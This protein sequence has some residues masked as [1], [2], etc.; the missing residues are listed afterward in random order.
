MAVFVIIGAGHVVGSVERVELHVR[1]GRKSNRPL[2]RLLVSA[3]EPFFLAAHVVTS[4]IFEHAARDYQALNLGRPLVNLGDLPTAK[5]AL[6]FAFF[7][8]PV[9]TVTF[10]APA[11]RL[12]PS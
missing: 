7:C 5:I 4:A 11:P 12:P 9:A 8:L 1:H 2:A 10:H 3:L 6:A